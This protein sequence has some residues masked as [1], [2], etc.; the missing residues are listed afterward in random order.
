MVI[1]TDLWTGPEEKVANTEVLETCV[2][3]RLVWGRA[4]K[5]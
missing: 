5:P 4:V 3:G 1:D 2:G